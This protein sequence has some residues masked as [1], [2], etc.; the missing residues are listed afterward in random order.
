M[1]KSVPM[2]TALLFLSGVALARFFDYISPARFPDD[3]NWSEPEHYQT[4]WKNG[5]EL[6][7]KEIQQSTVTVPTAP[8]MPQ[9]K[10]PEPGKPDGE[11]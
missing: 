8:E 11:N 5:D 4:T 9:F 3:W 2:V 1:R 6:T 10:T 7:H